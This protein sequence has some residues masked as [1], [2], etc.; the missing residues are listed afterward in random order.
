MPS[1]TAHGPRV[2]S[3]LPAATEIVCVLGGRALLVGRS[4]E[5]DHPEDV[6][7][8]P[9]VSRPRT[10]MPDASDAVDR[11]VRELVR[12]TLSIYEID[13]AA[14]ARLAPDVVVTQDV[15]EVCAVGRDDV[16]D[17]VAQVVSDDVDVVSLSPTCLA[18][19]LED[20]RRVATAIGAQATADRVVAGL[21]RRLD[22]V[23]Q[24]VAGRPRPSVATIEWVEPL[25]AGGNWMPELVEL[26]GGRNLLGVAGAH[27]PCI[28]PGGLL[29]ADPDRVLV[30]PCGW[31]LDR[32]ERDL[33]TLESTDWWGGLRAV[34]EGGV[35]VADGHRFFNRPGPRIVESVE[36][37]AEWLHPDL[38]RLGH[39]GV[40]FRRAAARAQDAA[41]RAPLPDVSRRRWERT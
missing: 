10:A 23:R 40:A 28:E 8:L 1:A 32:A 3:L 39:E 7:E 21:R 38:G 22:Q 36:I 37:L 27:S 9:V 26:A 15:C 18:D 34:R 11:T 31:D 29:A 30:A 2:V 4:H 6:V 33:A 20:H 14:L 17:A 24:L 25:M 5:C 41:L 16:L 19:V 35:A 13:D 12:Q